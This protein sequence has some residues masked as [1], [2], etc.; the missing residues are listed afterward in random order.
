MAERPE[1]KDWAIGDPFSAGH[2]NQPLPTVRSVQSVVGGPGIAVTQGPGGTV[3][4]TLPP[5]TQPAPQPVWIKIIGQLSGDGV[6]TCKI[7]QPNNSPESPF[8]PSSDGA[9]FDFNDF[10]YPLDSGLDYNAV[11]VNLAEENKTPHWLDAGGKYPGWYHPCPTT[12]GFP[13]ILGHVFDTQLCE[14]A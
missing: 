4:S 3:I 5:T 7:G 6:Y 14:D 12:D 9:E 11:F 10:D 1:I 8:D 13:L 2:L